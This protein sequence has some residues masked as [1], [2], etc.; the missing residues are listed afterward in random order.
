MRLKRLYESENF[1]ADGFT[2]APR[3]GNHRNFQTG[4]C[5]ILRS[6]QGLDRIV[7]LAAQT[8]RGG[9]GYRGDYSKVYIVATV[10]FS[11]GIG[12]RAVF[13]YPDHIQMIDFTEDKE[14]AIRLYDSVSHEIKL[15]KMDLYAHEEDPIGDAILRRVPVK[16]WH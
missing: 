1:W 14:E 11:E 16:D 10:P 4:P 12:N 6:F 3:L 2:L 5:K 15:E 8:R 9:G 7:F 13:D